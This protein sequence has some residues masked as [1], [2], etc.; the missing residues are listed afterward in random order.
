M[1]KR[2]AWLAVHKTAVVG[3]E[4]HD[5]DPVAW[6]SPSAFSED[7]TGLCCGAACGG[8]PPLSCRR[9]RRNSPGREA[10]PP[11]P[12]LPWAGFFDVALSPPFLRGVR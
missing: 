1:T 2:Y 3:A 9:V 11:S 4:R 12:L 7:F 6:L 5:I 10:V 8:L